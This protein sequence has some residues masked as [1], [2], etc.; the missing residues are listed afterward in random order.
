MIPTGLYYFFFLQMTSQPK[1]IWHHGSNI[2]HQDKTG[3][4]CLL[5]FLCY[6]HV[7]M[8]LTNYNIFTLLSKIYKFKKFKLPSGYGKTCSTSILP[9]K[10]FMANDLDSETWRFWMDDMAGM[11]CLSKKPEIKQIRK[12][13]ILKL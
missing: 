8:Y 12:R 3:N 2:D 5:T 9:R 10:M 4:V 11:H 7:L 1:N 6:P 13:P